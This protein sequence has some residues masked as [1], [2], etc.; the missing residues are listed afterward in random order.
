MY[1]YVY[2]CVRLVCGRMCERALA[3]T[4]C[5]HE[6]RECAHANE[7]DGTPVNSSTPLELMRIYTYTHN[8]NS[9][10]DARG[11]CAFDLSAESR[12]AC[13]F[14]CANVFC[15]LSKS[16]TFRAREIALA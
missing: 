1:L 8:N 16:I 14:V 12:H 13:V 9:R 7:E 10:L 5:R 6:V 3:C 2:I 11:S 15:L 4:M